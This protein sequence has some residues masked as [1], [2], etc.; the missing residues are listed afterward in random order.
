VESLLLDYNSVARD[1]PALIQSGLMKW[2]LQI[3][4]RPHPDLPDVPL[5]INLAENDQ[6]R[7][8]FSFLSASRR[9]GKAFIAPPETPADRTEA[10]RAAF[11]SMLADPVFV[12]EATKLGM[13]VE[14]RPWQAVADVIRETVDVDP[15]IAATVQKLTAAPN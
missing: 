10:L 4:D 3:G 11:Q 1:S 6:Q 8:I 5:L 12:E 7:L 9:M 2:L 14:P 15:Q 13:K